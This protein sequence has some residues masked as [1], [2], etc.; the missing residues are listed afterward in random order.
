MNPAKSESKQNIEL[1]K[2]N[3]DR[4]RAQI[5]TGAVSPDNSPQVFGEFV[6][7]GHV[8]YSALDLRDPSTPQDCELLVYLF[9]LANDKQDNPSKRSAADAIV[10]RE[11]GIHRQKLAQIESKVDRE[12]EA[13]LSRDEVN[14]H[15]KSGKAWTSWREL[16]KNVAARLPRLDVHINP[17]RR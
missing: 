5:E 2:S 6:S 9:T 13:A 1:A 15:N 10:L 11:I 16:N 3:L 12:G 7:A 14:L 17:P 8:Y 4:I